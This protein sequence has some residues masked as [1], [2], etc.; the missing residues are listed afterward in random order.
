MAFFL[1]C[2]ISTGVEAQYSK[3]SFFVDNEP[4]HGGSVTAH[5]KTDTALYIG[6]QSFDNALNTAFVSKLD[7]QGNVIWSTTADPS[8]A[9]LNNRLIHKMFLSDNVIYALV[10]KNFDPTFKI[11]WR[12]D[13]ATGKSLSKKSFYSTYRSKEVHFQDYDST[14]LLMSYDVSSQTPYFALV[15]KLTGDTTSTR[16][17]GKFNNF[18]FGLASDRS[19]NIYYSFQGDI[20]K[21]GGN[22]LNNVLW[23]KDLKNTTAS[24]KEVISI[25]VDSTNRVFVFAK[26]TAWR[27]TDAAVIMEI[28]PSN[29]DILWETFATDRDEV[30]DVKL[31]DRDGFFYTSWL[32]AYTNNG[33]FHISKLKKSD[34]NLTWY[35]SHGITGFGD[36][37]HSHSSFGSAA[38]SLDLDDSSNIYLTGYYGDAN[39]SAECWGIMKVEPKFGNRVYDLTIT[40]DSS[41]FDNISIGEV[42]CVFNGRPFF[43]GQVQ[44]YHEH[45][46]ERALLTLLKVDA[47]TG[48]IVEQKNLLGKYQ[49]ES[50]TLDL[51]PFV[52]GRTLAMKQVGRKV[53]IDCYSNAGAKIWSTELSKEYFL[54]GVSMSTHDDSL[55]SVL[56]FNQT[57]MDAEPYHED[58]LDTF[59][60]FTINQHGGLVKEEY[61]IF[62]STDG[63]PL[64]YHRSKNRNH[65]LYERNNLIRL[66]RVSTGFSYPEINLGV[67]HDN[68]F[69][70]E[71]YAVDLSDSFLLFFGK[72]INKE[73]IILI[74]KFTTDTTI[75]SEQSPG[76][77]R[78]N[79]SMKQKTNVLVFGQGDDRNFSDAMALYDYKK[80]DTIWTRY[81]DPK[82]TFHMAVY[83]ADSSA[84]F[85]IGESLDSMIVR[86]ISATSGNPIW[87]YAYH[88]DKNTAKVNFTDLAIDEKKQLLIVTGN[89]MDSMSGGVHQNA[90]ILALNLDGKH[91]TTKVETGNLFRTQSANCA[92]VLPDH[93]FWIGGNLHTDSL[94]NTGFIFSID[95]VVEPIIIV[96]AK[97]ADGND[98]GIASSYPN[99]FSHQLS[100]SYTVNE[101]NS[102]VELSLYD[103]A[104]KELFYKQL[105][106][107][108]IGERTATI[109][110][111]VKPGLYLMKLS[112]NQYSEVF[113]VVKN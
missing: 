62:R 112:V 90:L 44:T 113:R 13:A 60:V 105:R 86:K 18:R 12:I 88:G 8:I 14:H 67:R 57:Y 22:N 93:S 49:F 110:P 37:T 107:E 82:S 5:I 50:A 46:E 91:L 63:T 35:K 104:G 98:F 71:N 38:I 64:S 52:L 92:H 77:K 6:G 103:L 55:I 99:P 19:K 16:Y 17:M 74:N 51:K 10:T 97:N 47:P 20:Y 24:V 28:D 81:Y 66:R 27:K 30:N 33:A 9:E 7:S 21:L 39:F 3:K 43:I 2:L 15:N 108:S 111:I 1:L 102:S 76:F 40:R 26:T 32:P 4:K 61:L 89:Q 73:P 68:S 25:Y 84:I 11:I 109:R 75:L 34:G 85:T 83:N 48:K 45:Y 87:K 59:F 69:S 53:M 65:L 95:T 58:N 96:N 29:G 54:K 36:R 94:G 23:Q 101:N 70:T 31:I 79:Y 56:T 72:W 41:H 100:V 106:G 78:I 80:R 42:A